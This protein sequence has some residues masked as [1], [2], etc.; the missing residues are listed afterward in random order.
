M[1]ATNSRLLAAAPAQLVIDGRRLDAS[2]PRGGG[3]QQQGQAV[4]PAGNGNAKLRPRS[5]QGRQ[6]G[7]EPGDQ[8]GSGKRVASVTRPI[9]STSARHFAAARAEGSNCCSW[10]RMVDP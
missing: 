5:G 8:V 1:P 3:E 9:I 6:I 7:F 10:E 2:R 4:R